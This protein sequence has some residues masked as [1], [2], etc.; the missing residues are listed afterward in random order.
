MPSATAYGIA[1]R[2]KDLK[3]RG[4][5]STEP[6]CTSGR[7][8]ALVTNRPECN[9]ACPNGPRPAETS[10]HRARPLAATHTAFW[11]LL[12]LGRW[13]RGRRSFQVCGSI[14]RG[15]DAPLSSGS[16]SAAANASGGAPVITRWPTVNWAMGRVVFRP[17]FQ[18]V[19]LLKTARNRPTISA[20]MPIRRRRDRRRGR[21]GEDCER[22]GHL[23]ARRTDVAGV[24]LEL[25]IAQRSSI[26]AV[27]ADPRSVAG[28]FG[29][30]DRGRRLCGGARRLRGSSQS[31]ASRSKG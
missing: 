28:L 20:A 14:C 17:A 22:P 30:G 7:P 13:A 19:K 24:R 4:T 15:A 11:A 27:A 12:S 25:G 21:A 26:V 5:E 3:H 2:F 31:V 23:R 29:E 18:P 1:A 10:N 6:V 8:G 16:W 9:C